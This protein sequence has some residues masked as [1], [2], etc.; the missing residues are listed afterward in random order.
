M[1]KSIEFIEYLYYNLEFCD[2]QGNHRKKIVL[3]YS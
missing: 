3:T 1:I 2:C